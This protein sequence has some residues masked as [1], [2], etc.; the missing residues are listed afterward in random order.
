MTGVSRCSRPGQSRNK[1][2]CDSSHKGAEFRTLDYQAVKRAGHRGNRL[3]LGI[4]IDNVRSGSNC[5][6]VIG[7]DTLDGSPDDG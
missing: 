3:T 6:A 5:S 4:T 2:F 1:P 7:F